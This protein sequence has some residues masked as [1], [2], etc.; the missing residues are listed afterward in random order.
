MPL[1]RQ[2]SA[3][4]AVI[5][6]WSIWV[7]C[8]PEVTRHVLSFI[9]AEVGCLKTSGAS[10]VS[11]ERSQISIGY[12]YKLYRFWCILAVTSA[13]ALHKRLLRWCS[14]TP[15]AC[16]SKAAARARAS[17]AIRLLWRSCVDTAVIGIAILSSR[18]SWA[19]QRSL[20]TAHDQ[21]EDYLRQAGP[22]S[23]APAAL[24]IDPGKLAD[25]VCS[26]ASLYCVAPTP[27]SSPLQAVLLLL[28]PAAGRGPVQP[29]QSV[30]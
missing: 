26:A 28:R 24:E 10:S 9:S 6:D 4:D 19:S 17:T 18:W 13:K 14:R 21:T 23:E 15:P 25:A 30:L 7:R 3:T 20:R 11:R 5:G 29:R 12:A 27:G 16:R 2:N 1:S 8:Y 22:Q